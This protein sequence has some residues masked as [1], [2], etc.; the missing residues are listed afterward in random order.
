VN[1]VVVVVV[2]ILSVIHCSFLQSSIHP[3][4][5]LS[6]KKQTVGQTIK[7]ISLV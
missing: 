7:Q 4:T 5:Q 2:D 3:N 1:V 6:K